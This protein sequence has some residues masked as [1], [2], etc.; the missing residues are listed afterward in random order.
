MSIAH[1]SQKD[2]KKVLRKK[3]N[4]YKDWLCDH[5]KDSK[6]SIYNDYRKML[7]KLKHACKL[8]YYNDKC[9]E[10]KNDSKKLWSLINKINGKLSDKSTIID[11]IYIDNLIMTDT[12][13]IS[14]D[15]A[16][17][18]SSVGPKFAR[19]HEA[20]VSC[21]FKHQVTDVFLVFPQ[22]SRSN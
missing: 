2:Y 17:F 18:F 16:K 14:N 10:F 8:R 7:Q 22:S 21:I 20:G 12:K 3:N 1:G 19:H 6:M 9:C 11:K 4:L 15:F 13:Q 5:T